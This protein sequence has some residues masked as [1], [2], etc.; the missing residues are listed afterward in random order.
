MSGTD[1]LL[2]GAYVSESVLK[3]PT[4]GKWISPY[5]RLP[6]AKRSQPTLPYSTVRSTR[7]NPSLHL[8][9]LTVA[10][11]KGW[12]FFLFY[13]LLDRL[14]RCLAMPGNPF[15][16]R[17]SQSSSSCPVTPALAPCLFGHR[18]VDAHRV[19]QHSTSFAHFFACSRRVESFINS[20]FLF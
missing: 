19:L 12:S 18:R 10:Y 7:L 17:R 4:V 6:P 8:P 16:P 1:S 11:N 9:H 5:T 13:L 14:A 3:I 15:C 2:N 20:F